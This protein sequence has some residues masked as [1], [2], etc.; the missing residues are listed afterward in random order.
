M[1]KKKFD[2]VIETVRYAP[3]GKIE[4]VRAYERR[5]PTFSDWV[6]I[7][8][9]TLVERLKAGKKFV[10][11]RRIPFLSSTFEISL[12][13]RLAGSNGGAVILAGEADSSR[14][15]LPGVPLV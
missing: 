12:P 8:R 9:P 6:L 3:D 5:G 1:A 7:D 10:T 15:S 2:G 4:W 14:D 11:G 13:V